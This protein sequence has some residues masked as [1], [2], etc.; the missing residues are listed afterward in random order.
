MPLYASLK[1]IFGKKLFVNY[2]FPQKFLLNFQK[3]NQYK[4]IY[5]FNINLIN[6]ITL[7]IFHNNFLYLLRKETLVSKKAA[8]ME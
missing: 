6:I 8:P 5:Y 7:T 1:H 2:I 3:L 4:K